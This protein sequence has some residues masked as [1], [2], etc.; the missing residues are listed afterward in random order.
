[1][2]IWKSYEKEIHHSLLNVKVLFLNRNCWEIGDY[3][4]KVMLC[5]CSSIISIG[6]GESLIILH[7]YVS[8]FIQVWF[9]N[10]SSALPCSGAT[11][12][13]SHA[14]PGMKSDTDSLELSHTKNITCLYSAYAK[15][16]L[17]LE[18]IFRGKKHYPNRKPI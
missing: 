12:K 5:T 11:Q 13:S 16:V 15:G 10:Q 9:S 14:G 4:W 7:I 18:H 8:V 1:M 6:R 3:F 17:Q 2:A